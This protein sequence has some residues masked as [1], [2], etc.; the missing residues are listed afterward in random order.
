M[1]PLQETERP[2]NPKSDAKPVVMCQY[3]GERPVV[4]YG[5]GGQGLCITCQA[6]VMEAY[7]SSPSKP[8]NPKDIIGS[9]KLP[10]DLVPD[11]A[12]AYAALGHLEGMLKYGLVNWR[13]CG[14]RTSIYLGALSRHIAKFKNGE[15]EDPVTKVPHLGSALACINIIIDAYECGKMIDDRPKSAP[16]A[17]LIDRFSEKVKHLKRLFA[18]YHPHHYTISES[19][20]ALP[21]LEPGARPPSRV[22]TPG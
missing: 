15:W 20:E 2:T 13:E 6:R 21:V 12:L 18:E 16:V 8:S 9:D 5:P 17:G 1:T 7:P 14:V 3:C 11:T 10:L 22:G 4:Y 19:D